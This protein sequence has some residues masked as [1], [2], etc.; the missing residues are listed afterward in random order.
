MILFIEWAPPPDDDKPGPE[1]KDAL[2][3]VMVMEF[4]EC[5]PPDAAGPGPEE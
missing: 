2:A 4:M 1:E 3:G 5:I